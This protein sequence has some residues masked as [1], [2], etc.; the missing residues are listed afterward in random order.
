MQM[1]NISLEIRDSKV[2]FT[3]ILHKH[4]IQIVSFHL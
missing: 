3:A 4:F 2:K 1:L